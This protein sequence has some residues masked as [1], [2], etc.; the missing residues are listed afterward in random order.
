MTRQYIRC[1]L[2]VFIFMFSLH[3]QETVRVLKSQKTFIYSINEKDTLLLI[4]F[5]C[6]SF[7]AE[8]IHLSSISFETNDSPRYDTV[9]FTFTNHEL[10]CYN[11]KNENGITDSLIFVNRFDQKN[12]LIYDSAMFRWRKERVK[13][14][15]D[16]NGKIS[17]EERTDFL[18]N[19]QTEI[20]H[21]DWGDSTICVGPKGFYEVVVSKNYNGKRISLQ[22][23]SLDG[24]LQGT[25]R[26]VT[27][28]V[29]AIKNKNGKTLNHYNCG[30][31]YDGSMKTWLSHIEVLDKKDSLISETY[32]SP[33]F[34]W[35][36]FEQ[37]YERTILR[38][39][40][41]KKLMQVE[42]R[43]NNIDS[44]FY[45]SPLLEIVHRTNEEGIQRTDSVF[46]SSGNASFRTVTYIGQELIESYFVISN[47][48]EYIE[49]DTLYENGKVVYLEINEK[50][51]Y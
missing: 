21:F 22:T 37:T 17:K 41:G 11:V 26:F 12:R 42:S 49:K 50:K 28:S 8:G 36:K 14:W 30:R 24:K 47:A 5:L 6:D 23:Y 35:K 25:Y 31:S 1:F 34:F 39:R 46:Y 19:M 44:T 45:I 29:V 32:Y 33:D 3:G 40:K 2:P 9:H 4:S 18:S 13:Y 43:A 10:H 48:T 38:D 16:E 20:F 15:Y 27:D 7:S 51:Y